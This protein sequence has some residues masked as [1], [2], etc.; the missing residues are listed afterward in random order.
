MLLLRYGSWSSLEIVR[1]E[2]IF[3][4]HFHRASVFWLLFL[5]MQKSNA[6][7]AVQMLEVGTMPFQIVLCF[8]RFVTIFAK[9]QKYAPKLIGFIGILVTAGSTK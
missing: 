9:G 8:Y 5:A 7:T 6:R 2:A 4:L 1:D 3:S